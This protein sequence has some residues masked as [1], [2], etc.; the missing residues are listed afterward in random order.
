[1]AA[2]DARWDVRRRSAH[3]FR[4]HHLAGA[5]LLHF[6]GAAVVDDLGPARLLGIGPRL[7]RVFFATDASEES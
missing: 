2:I 3:E 5:R 1:M 6:A 7:H 4:L